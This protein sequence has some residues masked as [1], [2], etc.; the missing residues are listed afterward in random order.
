M[1]A[2]T[3]KTTRKTPAKSKRKY[4]PDP[5][6]KPYAEVVA[7]SIIAALE[8]GRAPWQKPWKPGRPGAGAPYNPVSGTV[9]K[10]INRLNLMISP[11]V[12]PRWMTYKQASDAG[13]QVRRGEKGTMIQYWSWEKMANKTDDNGKP[14]LD[15]KGKPVRVKVRL[16][17]PVAFYATVFNAEQIDGLEPYVEPEP[18]EE[19]WERHQRAEHIIEHSGA[20]IDHQEQDRAFYSVI[21]DR[22]V[23]PM[24][25]QFAEA[26]LYYATLLH[27]LG[28]W[29]GHK[30]RLNRDLTGSFGSESYAKEELRAEISSMMVGI[31]LGIGHDP[32]Q[33]VSYVGSWIRALKNDPLEIFR[34]AADAEKIKDYILGLELDPNYSPKKES[35]A[36]KELD[37]SPSPY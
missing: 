37:S 10:G 24:R 1:T 9:Y 18:L 25:H 21:Q 15:E 6:K 36:E 30:S 17:R 2:N 7:E 20:A 29:T 11:Y 28:H 33:H 12:D 32:G 23:M 13:A 22:I 3:K 16:S 8:A 26:D 34:A 31:E 5:D 19:S 35:K 14:V 27:E 4:T